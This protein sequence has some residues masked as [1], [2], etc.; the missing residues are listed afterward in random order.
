MLGNISETGFARLRGRLISSA[1]AFSQEDDSLKNDT[2]V[3]LLLEWRG[4]RLLFPGDAEWRSGQFRK[5]KRNSSWD[6]M[7]NDARVRGLLEKGLHYWK[8]GHH[9]SINGTPYYSKRDDQPLLE[10]LAPADVK[11]KA[12]PEIVVSSWSGKFTSGN[13]VPH[14]AVMHELGRRTATSRVYVSGEPQPLR[15][16]LEAGIP[17]E[18]ARFV[19]VELGAAPPA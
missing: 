4:R 12:K 15:T 16:D 11:P 14:P 6:V 9:G 18:S 17:G 7:W 13:P 2:S 1:L 10:K 19:D 5:G 8:V 3:V